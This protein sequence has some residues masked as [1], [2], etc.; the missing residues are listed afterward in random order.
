MQRHTKTEIVNDSS[1]TALER[2]VKILLRGG[3]EGA[4]RGGGGE[5]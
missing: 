4:G 2:S 1:C 3:G 5:A